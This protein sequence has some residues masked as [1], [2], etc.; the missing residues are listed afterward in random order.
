MKELNIACDVLIAGG[1]ISGVAAAVSAARSGAQTILIEKTR[2]LGG[3]ST[4]ALLRHICGLYLN[5]DEYP[6]ETL[7]NGFTDEVVAG[8]S[9][10]SPHSKV[11]K[12]GK[13]FV[14]PYSGVDLMQVMSS[15]CRSESNLSVFLDACAV[16]VSCAGQTIKEVLIYMSGNKRRIFPKAVIDCTG[17]GEVAYMA[18]ASFEE[19]PG[20]ESQLAGY[21]IRL[22]G[23]HTEDEMLPVKVPYYMAQAVSEGLLPSSFKFTVFSSGDLPDE[24]YLKFGIEAPFNLKY[25]AAFER[26]AHNALRYLADKIP[27][28]K[29]CLIVETS[30]GVFER[31]GRRI[32]GQYMLTGEDVLRARKF[33]EGGVKNSWPIELWNRKRGSVYKYVKANDYYEIPLSCQKSIDI[34]NLLTAGRCIS[35]THEALGSTRVMGTC[36]A[37]GEQA[38]RAA[39]GM[40]RERDYAG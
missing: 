35:V 28:F 13:V 30:K 1:G 32:C 6:S 9:K 3:T 4:S 36:M 39:A 23:L 31:E 25:H 21:T 38:G 14:L 22:R 11:I 24:G 17:N 19:T 40:A 27:S 10:L 20:G 33:P 15:L 18:G 2:I 12:T 29:G 5:G 34:K 8:L 37:L 26:D 7:N 16:S